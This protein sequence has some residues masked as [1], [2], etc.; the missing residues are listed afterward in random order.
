MGAD[1]RFTRAAVASTVIVT[2][3]W[4]RGP[5][6]VRRR[7]AVFAVVAGLGTG[8]WVG[9]DG[10]L[11]SVADRWIVSDPIGPADAVA[12]F[13]GGIL[14][15][16]FAAA[17]YYRQG[18]VRKILVSNNGHDSATEKPDGI[19][20]EVALTEGILLKLGVPATAIETFGN[21]LGNTHQEVLA[22]QA[23]AERND[24]RSIIVPT[25]T[26]STRRVRWMLDRVFGGGHVI[27]VIA[28][29]PPPFRRDDWWR[30]W[31]GI[32]AFR[33]E[34]LKYIFYRLIY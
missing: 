31:Q 29:E 23:W 5:K 19:V 3:I 21:N 14:D 2:K 1:D 27:R 10:L 24:V 15:R 7:L 18:L 26:F 13:G 6:Q 33:N 20:S 22:L 17:R 32:T 30:H 28:L 16:P 4:Y 34:I 8:A 9:R 25:E 12:V 11:V